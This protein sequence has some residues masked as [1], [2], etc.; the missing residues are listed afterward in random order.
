MARFWVGFGV[1]LALFWLIDRA[2]FRPIR[3]DSAEL[4]ARRIREKAYRGG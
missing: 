3:R 1:V 4:E 2:V